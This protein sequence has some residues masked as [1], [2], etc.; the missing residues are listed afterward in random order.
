M[1]HSTLSFA[2]GSHCCRGHRCRVWPPVT[3]LVG[4][5]REAAAATSVGG[6]RLPAGEKV[7]INVFA[8]HHD[9]RYWPEPEVC[10][11][12][13]GPPTAAAAVSRATEGIMPTQSNGVLGRSRKERVCLRCSSSTSGQ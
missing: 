8:I 1:C 11:L 7:W 2:Q 13:L 4:L 6:Y 9:E 3:P 10:T 12:T 5:Q